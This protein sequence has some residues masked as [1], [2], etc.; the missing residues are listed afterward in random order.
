AQCV[1]ARSIQP[2]LLKSKATAPA[3]GAGNG[4]FHGSTGRNG[5]SRLFR[6]AAAVLR[7]P[8]RMKSIAR[9]LLKSV[10]RAEMPGASPL[11]TACAV[12]S[13]KVPLPLLRH[14]LFD[15]AVC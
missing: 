13:V 4:D 6:N 8:V 15:A 10:A 2:S 9:S 14:R 3:A 1:K 5:P 11:R 7:H 12:Q